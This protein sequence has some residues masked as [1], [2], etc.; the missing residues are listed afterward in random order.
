M[1]RI[2]TIL[3]VTVL[4]LSSAATAY[5]HPAKQTSIYWGESVGWDI[6]EK[7]RADPEIIT[8]IWPLLSRGFPHFYHLEPE[9]SE[10]S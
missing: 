4:V 6:C 10:N 3:L 8:S 1:K 9:V 7:S 2:V 5:A